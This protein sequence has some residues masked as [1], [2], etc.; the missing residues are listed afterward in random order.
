MRSMDFLGMVATLKDQGLS[1]SQIAKGLGLDS[2]TEL[3]A[4]TTIANNAK[5]QADISTAERLKAKQMSNIAI[6]EQMGI[7]ESSVRALLAPG[8]KDK[9]DSLLLISSFLKSQVDEN[10]GFLD[11]GTGVESHLQIAETRL[12]VAVSVLKDQGYEVHKVQIDQ[13]GTKYKTVVRVLTPPGT[14]YKDVVTNKDKIFTLTGYSEDGGRSIL[15]ILPPVQVSSKRIAIKYDEDGGSKEDGLIY[16]RPGVP[17]LSMGKAR[18]A[19]VRIAVDGT[20]YL[21]GMAMYRDDL[22]DG[23]DL[24]FNTNKKLSDIGPNKLDAMKKLKAD[25]VTGVIDEDNPFGS[26]V[27]QLKETKSDGSEK[28]VSAMNLVNEEGK[29]EDWKSSIAP[30][31]LSKQSPLL[32]KTQLAVTYERKKAELDEITALTNPAVR[33][34][35]LESYADDADASAVH[36]KAAG[37]PRQASQVI[38][39]IPSMKDT[40]VYAPNFRPGE[41]VV[42]IRYPHGGKFEIPE[43]TVNNDNPEAKSLLGN[44]RDAIGINHVVAERLSGADFDGDTVLVIP[45]VGPNGTDYIKTSPALAGLKNFQPQVLYKGYEGMPEMSS[46]TKGIE[47]GLVSNLITD[48]TIRGAST[49]ELARA[50]RHSMVVIDAEKHTLNYKQSAIDNNISE[51]KLTYQG[52]KETGSVGGASTLL[53]KATSEIR[54]AEQRPRKA[55]DIPT[56]KRMKTEGL[57]TAE[58]AD[59]M[60]LTEDSVKSLLKPGAQ[61]GSVDP[62]TGR[63]VFVQTG[64]QYV[65]PKVNK[66]TGEVTEKVTVKTTKLKRLEATDDAFDLIDPA[67][68]TVMEKT[69]AEHSNKLKALANTA[70]KEALATKPVPYSPSAKEAYSKQVKELDAAL[71]LARRNRPLERQALVLANTAISLKVRDNPD[72]DDADLKKI[73]G[74]ALMEARSRTGAEKIKIAPTPDQWAA[75]QAGAIS[76]HK[77]T[78]ILKNADIDVVKQLATPKVK[79]VISSAMSTRARAMIANGYTQGEIAAALGVPLSTLKDDLYG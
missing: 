43:L 11:I 17:E 48:M 50:V 10:G 73:K 15:G 57:S 22:P 55:A 27:R 25:K 77:L 19:Q 51:L 8:A 37:L 62:A 54:V 5:K 4:A 76:N 60:K 79:P 38:L 69:Y 70:R 66:R 32:A 20:H 12:K 52:R 78:E 30:Q 28:V 42:L 18:Y 63:K 14:T 65:T 46:R 68:Q 44:A 39:P 2:T 24:V 71:D 26:V 72:M 67:R 23:V 56:A 1:P 21:K 33:K 74:Q 49:D 6:G 31:V 47:M 16:V 75:I 3:R 29:W 45:N 7:N 36:L 41:R 34:K 40:E 59:K 58:I 9:A 61:G 64:A 53:S 13:P 35:L